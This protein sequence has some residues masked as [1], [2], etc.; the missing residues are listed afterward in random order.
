MRTWVRTSAVAV[1]VALAGVVGPVAVTPAVAADPGTVTFT[2]RGFGH[3]RG[4]GQYGALGY[5]VDLGWDHERILRHYYGGA[6][7]A[8]DAGNPALS[9]ELTRN[10]GRSVVVEGPGI[11]VGGVVTGG[12]AVLVERTGGGRFDVR[13]GPSCGGPWTLWKSGVESGAVIATANGAPTV[14]EADRWTMY[15]GSLRVVERSGTSYLLNDVSVDDYLRGVLPREV[16][17]S[18]AG[19]GGGRG[20]EGLRAQAVAARSYALASSR[21]TSGATT[22]DTTA[23][24]VYGGHAEQFY[25]KAVKVLEDA[26]TDTAVA[27]TSG[28]V[29]RT[30]AG[31]VARAEYSSSTGGWTAG[32][33]FPAVEDLGDAT[34]SNPNRSWTVSVAASRVASALGTGQIRSI[35]VNA[36]SGL[37]A[38]GGRVQQVVVVDTAGRT[39][40]F[41]GDT[42][43]SRLG[44]KSDWFTV[45]GQGARNE[46]EAVVRALYNDVLGREPE[47]AGLANWTNVVA[48]TNNPRLVADGIVNSKERLQ[49]L[50]TTEYVRA[51][52]RGPEPEG[53]ANWVGYMERGATVSDL[54]IGIFASQESLNVLGGGDTRAWV[55]GMYAALL[56]RPA[57]AAE[58]AEWAAVAQRQG[59][60]AAVAGIARSPEAGTQRLLA[61]YQRFLGRGL[62]PSG[63]ASWL[64]AMS[65]R[66]DFTI[67][68]MIGGSQEYWNRAQARFP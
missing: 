37:G 64:P 9:V 35:A 54:Q 59:R 21:P 12:R 68:G 65:G 43:R 60:G 53:L 5:A 14:C 23:C 6:T 24:Q 42:V 28:K 47:P 63:I 56:G 39:S 26:R 52:R 16:P 22:C 11:A 34:S 66:G 67:P 31:A 7:L 10:T 8:R 19:L 3:G 32:G 58:T 38:D 48:T 15:R 33:V 2:G 13:T 1:A 41:S 20:A 40:T 4:M 45:T 36:R 30:A 18:W 50:V 25:G 55:A 49:A 61:Y 44:L 29:M 57:S 17:A 62:D 51:L 27:D 46:A